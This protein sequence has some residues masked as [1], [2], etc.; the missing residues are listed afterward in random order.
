MYV[1]ESGSSGPASSLMTT[2]SAA[3]VRSNY[4]SVLVHQAQCGV[5]NTEVAMMTTGS[6]QNFSHSCLQ[7]ALVSQEN[8]DIKL[9]TISSLH[10]CS[11]YNSIN[12][13]IFYLNYS[14]LHVRGLNA[15]LIF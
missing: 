9:N 8:N 12:R 7:T 2:F 3:F 11:P 14:V 4:T 15:L 10:M 6:W 13:Q 1:K 5:F